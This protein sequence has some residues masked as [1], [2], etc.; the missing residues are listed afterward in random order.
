MKK[1]MII[2]IGFVLI[3]S[4]CF[5]QNLIV[6]GDFEQ[7]NKLFTS[8]YTY[9]TNSGSPEGVYKIDSDCLNWWGT[10]GFNCKDHTTGK[11]KMMYINGHFTSN[12]KIWSQTVNVKNKSTYTFSLWIA[13]LINESPAELNILVNNILIGTIKQNNVVTNV[14]KNYSFDWLSSSNIAVINIIDKNTTR[15]GN[16]FGIDDIKMIEKNV[17]SKASIFFPDTVSDVGIQNFKIPLKVRLYQDSLSYENISFSTSV[18][19]KANVFLITGVSANGTILSDTIDNDNYRNV[20]VYCENVNINDSNKVLT[21]LNGTVLLGDSISP[22]D[23]NYFRWH[24]PKLIVDSLIN[25][26]LLVKAC[27]LELRQIL[28]FNPIKLQ[29]Q[30]NP[31][32]NEVEVIITGDELG[33]YSIYLFDLQG[34]KMEEMHWKRT[35]KSDDS[36]KFRFNNISTGVYQVILK[37]PWSTISKPVIIVK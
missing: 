7:G 27:G 12:K 14:W 5:A 4:I 32:G 17:A 37:S 11:T 33:Y 2:I 19:F 3:Q 30:P 18:R 36:F 1:L 15:G 13:N 23:I 35:E 22:L 16:D 21:E 6:N 31:A 34:I 28:P 10:S 24:T 26:S 29:I 9:N 8:D 25:G 20:E